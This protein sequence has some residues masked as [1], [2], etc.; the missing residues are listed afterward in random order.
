MAC[1]GGK[2]I[3]VMGLNLIFGLKNQ[4]EAVLCIATTCMHLPRKPA[5]FLAKI[6]DLG[7]KVDVLLNPLMKYGR[8]KVL[9]SSSGLVLN[10]FSGLY[11]I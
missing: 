9:Y 5:M 2:W 8:E 7:D 10:L 11:L 3:H 4:F 6:E 1:P